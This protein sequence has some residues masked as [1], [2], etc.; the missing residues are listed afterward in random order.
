[1]P[2]LDAA[3]CN[4]LDSAD[5]E[6]S[7]AE[8]R[9][10][11]APGGPGVIYLD[12]NSIGPMPLEAP[13]RMRAAL[14]DGWRVARRRAWNETDWLEQPR[15]LGAAIAPVLGAAPDD[16]LV[17]D[18]T[19]LNLYKLLRHALALAAPRRTILVERGIFPSNRHVAEGL[20]HAGLAH[21][22]FV[23]DPADAA[24]FAA[25]LAPGDVAVVSLSHV[26]YR[27]SRRLDMAGITAG[28]HAHGAL[29][30]WDLSHSAGAVRIGLRE[31]DVDLAVGCGYK[32]LCGGP[33]AP[34]FVYAHPRAR[35]DAWP[36][37]CGWMGHADTF[38]FAG[39]Y[40]PAAGIGRFQ[41]GTPPVL[42]NAAFA[43]AADIWRRVDPDALDARHRALTD[44][45]VRLIDERC[46][47][48]GLETSSPREHA[49]RGGHVAIRFEGA[50]PLASALV[51]AGV[52]VSARKPD[53]LRLAPHPLVTTHAELWEA[54]DRL[55]A[56]LADGRWRDRRFEKAAV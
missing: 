28:A 54:V 34:G 50:A 23:D 24:Q 37:I 48:F 9:T 33:G 45:L 39:E 31:A 27:T 8:A 13:Q 36:A 22:R 38:G 16:V 7:L 42:A 44:T 6:S 3:A 19:T 55:V 49:A 51:E 14:E 52:V 17:C 11:F 25:A 20:A 26:D 46:A 4:A 12:A 29:A 18:G 21:L 47:R 2:K 53:A 10:S 32:Y 41:V 5:V 30:L 43:A 1:M 15:R 40:E 35:T 56:I